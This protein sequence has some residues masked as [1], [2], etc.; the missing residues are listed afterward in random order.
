MN[1]KR[2]TIWL[3]SMLSLM[4][5]LSAY[6]LFTQ[7]TKSPDMLSDGTQTEQKAGATEANAGNSQIVVDQVDPADNAAADNSGISEQDKE[8]LNQIEAQGGVD[9]SEFAQAEEK[10]S[11]SNNEQ[12]DKLLADITNLQD[13]EDS[14]AAMEQ[15]DQLEEKNSKLTSIENE[16]MKSFQQA[17][18]NEEGNGYKVLVESDKLDKSQAANIIDLV[19][20]TLGVD[21]DQVS[22]QFI[23]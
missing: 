18:V 20:K 22:V 7:D 13:P 11:Q 5:V 17:I 15:L 8:V 2:Q 16:L 14:K 9:N 1:T 12:Q 3:V 21:A 19:M 6:Y 23:P 4:V 10:R